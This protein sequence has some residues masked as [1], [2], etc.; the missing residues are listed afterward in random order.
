MTADVYRQPQLAPYSAFKELEID[1]GGLRG[2]VVKAA[3]L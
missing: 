2:R 3:N 1:M